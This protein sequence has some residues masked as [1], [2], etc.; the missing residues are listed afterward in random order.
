MVQARAV[1]VRSRLDAV[2]SLLVERFG[3]RRVILFGSLADGGWSEAS[4]VDLAVEGLA[5]DWFE[6]WDAA[7]QALGP[8]WRLDLVPVEQARPALRQSIARGEVLHGGG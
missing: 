2:V 6:A 3:A 7:E 1:G 5:G 8:D 4:D